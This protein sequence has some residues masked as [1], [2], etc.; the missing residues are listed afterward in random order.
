MQMSF[1]TSTLGTTPYDLARE[2]INGSE[3]P[4]TASC[5]NIVV[6]FYEYEDWL[7]KYVTHAICLRCGA[8]KAGAL[9]ACREC[10]YLPTGAEEQA[11]SILL[12]EHY[13]EPKVLEAATAAIQSGQGV[14]FPEE[15]LRDMIVSVRSEEKR[16]EQL[17]QWTESSQ[18]FDRRLKIVA[19]VTLAAVACAAIAWWAAA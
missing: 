4:S 6:R 1:P 13:L 2:G 11:K 19:A 8:R 16:R 7:R 9:L 17:R 12:G 10:G 15:E 5:H 3:R 14:R 18:R